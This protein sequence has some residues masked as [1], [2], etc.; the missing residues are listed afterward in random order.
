MHGELNV[1]ENLSSRPNLDHLRRQ[2]K[3]LL[4]LL[5]AGDPEAVST[6]LNHLPAAR[7]M[8]AEQVRRTQFR[9][10]DAQ[11]A[12]A[13]KTGFASWPQLARH[14]EQLR[15]LE[16]TWIFSHLEIDGNA[17]PPAMFE[18][19]RI[20]IDGDR[21]RTESPEATYEGVFN[22][23]VESLPHE[24]DLD[25]VAGPEAGNRNLGIFRLEGEQLEIC[26]DMNGVSRPTEFR[27]SGGN[28]RAFE[29]LRRASQLRPDHV[30]GGTAPSHQLPRIAHDLAGFESVECAT[31]TRLQGEWS[32]VKMIRDGQEMPAAMLA[33]ALRSS[34]QNE[35]KITFG[36]QLMMHVLVRI[37]ETTVP[38]GVDY[39]NICGSAQG[40]VQ[41]GIMKWVGD[42]AC[43]NMVPPGQ[44][45]PDDFTSTA[46]SGCLLSQWRLKH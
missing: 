29:R 8:T 30:T 11:S 7:S 4:A 14:V 34:T 43:F 17:L 38:I 2:A 24:I 21:F 6:I 23:G 18:A 19:S 42:D 46:G 15:A 31:L 22:I 13:R 26:L 37:D 25:F 9:L 32:A 28:G 27:S 39:Y 3:S 12:I 44:R 33:T 16:G 1:A 41:H 45:R 20:L 35:V 5:E 40:T 10:A 36:G